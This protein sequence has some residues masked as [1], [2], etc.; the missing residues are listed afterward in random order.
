MPIV[1]IGV[2]LGEKY[3][4][5]SKLEKFIS[6]SISVLLKESNYKFKQAYCYD[7]KTDTE[8]E[9]LS[10]KQAL[11]KATQQ[12][13]FNN[14]TFKSD[15]GQDVEK[16]SI[17]ILDEKIAVHFSFDYDTIVKS[18][19]S[20]D[21]QT[22]ILSLRNVLYSIHAQTSFLFAFISGDAEFEKSYSQLLAEIGNS[23]CPYSLLMIMNQNELSDYWGEFDLLGL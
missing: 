7:E 8:T 16:I 22:L 23:D 10:F 19:N 5:S 12:N 2:C 1:D 21:A 11:E 20:C 14:F 9:N 18:H 4:N 15:S 17:S 3:N 13:C 6:E